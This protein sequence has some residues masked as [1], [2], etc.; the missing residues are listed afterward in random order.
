MKAMTVN[1]EAL[2]EKELPQRAD[3]KI[4]ILMYHNLVFGRTGNEYNRDIYNFEH[5]LAFIRKR[6]KV[7]DFNDL[8]AIGEKKM[9]LT[10]DAAIISFDDGDLS[11]YG[12]AYP[13]LREYGIKA[14]FFII[15]G[16]VGET[17]YMNWTQ[18]KELAAYRD[19]VLGPLFTIGSHGMDHAY[20][21]ELTSEKILEELVE[22]KA[23]LEKNTE[24]LVEILALPF[25]SGAGS[26]LI[27]ELALKA[28]Y[29]AIRTSDIKFMT[30]ATIDLL[31]L[32][33]I[34]VDNSSTDKVTQKIWTM[35]GR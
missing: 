7:I 11:I 9:E 20:M 32:P 35:L 12:L 28:G 25:G 26:S 21:G 2:A 17:G 5:D 29:K 8:I 15:T 27:S 1:D 13:L 34:Y 33:G 31:R 3:P 23:K 24:T 19:P 4:I 30:P 14:T 22:S 16:C 10:T 18:I 6:F